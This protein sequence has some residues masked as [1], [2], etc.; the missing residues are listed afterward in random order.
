MKI[1]KKIIIGIL[2]IIALFLI[3]Q[4]VNAAKYKMVVNVVEGENVMGVNPL[5]DKLDFGDLSRN[6]GMTRYVT[7]KS[8]GGISTYVLVWRMGEISD[9][10]KVDKNA[11]V[12]KPGEEVKL[13]FEIQIPP[14]AEIKKYS[15]RVWIFR[16]PKL[17]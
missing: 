10:I 5:A 11:F 9:L 16:L 13:S 7:M 6:N 12:L 17:W 3:I 15:G 2:I 4:I 1:V 14:S 8:G